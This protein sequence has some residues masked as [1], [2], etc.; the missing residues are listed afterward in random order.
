MSAPPTRPQPPLPSPLAGYSDPASAG[1]KQ[2][3]VGFAALE[4]SSSTATAEIAVNG[5]DPPELGFPPAEPTKGTSG[6]WRRLQANEIEA[7]VVKKK[8][9]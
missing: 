8:R 1:C 4:D 7:R 6:Q 3:T 2:F 9:I 5:M